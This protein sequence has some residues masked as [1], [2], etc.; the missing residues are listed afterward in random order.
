MELNSKKIV[1]ITKRGVRLL[2]I[3][4]FVGGVDSRPSSGPSVVFVA[5]S[6]PWRRDDVIIAANSDDIQR[7]VQLSHLAGWFK[8]LFTER[9]DSVEEHA[10]GNSSQFGRRCCRHRRRR[11]SSFIILKYKVCGEHDEKQHNEKLGSLLLL[12]TRNPTESSRAQHRH[13]RGT[14]LDG[15]RWMVTKSRRETIG[16]RLTVQPQRSLHTGEEGA[17]G[18]AHYRTHSAPRRSPFEFFPPQR[19]ICGRYGCFATRGLRF[20]FVFQSVSN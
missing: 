8:L 17:Q 12:Y 4:V 16:H 1:A 18:E 9:R 19:T 3:A 6:R 5:A 7:P 14:Y 11:S 13:R 20:F 15:V 10:Q 2:L